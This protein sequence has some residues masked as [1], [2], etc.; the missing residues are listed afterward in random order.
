MIVRRLVRAPPTIISGHW[1]GI[2]DGAA[3]IGIDISRTAKKVLYRLST[4]SRRTWDKLE[5]SSRHAALMTIAW[6][7][8]SRMSLKCST[9]MWRRVFKTLSL[10]L[11]SLFRAGHGSRGL[12]T[13]KRFICRT[14]EEQKMWQK[15]RRISSFR[16][17]VQKLDSNARLLRTS[18]SEAPER[19]FWISNSSN[20][21]F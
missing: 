2:P 8:P 5:T 17:W 7:S 16:R 4:S 12:R 13:F 11:K 6:H 3:L 20:F 15:L 1:F 19:L 10:S 18:Q 21:R 14:R 9:H